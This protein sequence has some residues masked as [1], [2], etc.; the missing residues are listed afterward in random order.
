MHLHAEAPLVSRPQ[1]VCL[2]KRS[3][4]KDSSVAI[5]SLASR[6]DLRSLPSPRP[7]ETR[8]VR[9]DKHALNRQVVQVLLVFSCTANTTGRRSGDQNAGMNGAR[10]I[11]CQGGTWKSG[12]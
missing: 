4:M 7:P 5:K 10:D 1:E 8:A 2:T 9:P 6:L 12:G 3:I 11:S